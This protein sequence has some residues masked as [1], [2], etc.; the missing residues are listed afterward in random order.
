MFFLFF[1]D[2]MAL[3][4]LSFLS[5]FLATS[6]QDSSCLINTSI[7]KYPNWTS[8]S[9]PMPV[10]P[11]RLLH[12]GHHWFFYCFHTHMQPGSSTYQM[13]QASD[14]LTLLPLLP[15]WSKPSSRLTWITAAA[16]NGLLC[17]CSCPCSVF[18]TH[19]PLNLLKGNLD[20]ITP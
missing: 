11:Y 17:F 9:I 15:L 5:L 19:Q 10:Q 12:V 16:S 2:S 4:W 6:Y 14:H 20:G 1:L 3:K 13:Y 7:L 8:P 18:S